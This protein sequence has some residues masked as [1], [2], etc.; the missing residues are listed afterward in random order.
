MEK[1]RNL[2]VKEACIF[3]KLLLT[4]SN[5]DLAD[6]FL[7]ET[8]RE[9]IGYAE[10]FGILEKYFIFKMVGACDSENQNPEEKMRVNY[11]YTL[12]HLLNKSKVL[13]IEGVIK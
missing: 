1:V 3:A 8:F 4:F 6:Q 13:G 11:L 10:K 7:N 5:V 9:D 2:N 12:Q